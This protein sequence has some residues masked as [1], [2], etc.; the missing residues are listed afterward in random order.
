MTLPRLHYLHRDGW[1]LA[2]ALAPDL[3]A[4]ATPG[5]EVLAL[6]RLLNLTGEGLQVDWVA[7]AFNTRYGGRFKP[8][9]TYGALYAAATQPA[10]ESEAAFSWARTFSST[11]ACPPPG[12]QVV[13]QVLR[14][15]L[16]G[17]FV[18][19]RKGHNALHD[20]DSHAASQTFGL[21]IQMEGWDG[22]GYRSVHSRRRGT[23]VVV[24]R[25]AVVVACVEAGQRVL[26]WDGATFTP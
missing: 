7:L 12:T 18:D 10:A 11:A 8:P 3:R 20:P 4:K 25:P 13:L 6:D 21:R 19:V 9:D 26:T 5:R 23:C 16:T 2:K 17:T 15:K 14:L 22:I 1:R 24:F